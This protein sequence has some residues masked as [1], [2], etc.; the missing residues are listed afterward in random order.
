M[1]A[2]EDGNGRGAGRAGRSR[3]VGCRWIV[4]S[5]AGVLCL[6][7]GPSAGAATATSTT[8]VVCAP[9]PVRPGA[10]TTCAATVTGPVHPTGT[11]SFA[12]NSSGTF[13]PVTC[14]LSQLGGNQARCTVAY[15]PAAATGPQRIYAN[16]SGDTGI[17]PSHGSSTVDVELGSTPAPG[18]V[19]ACS[20]A[21]IGVSETTVCT[22]TVTGGTP[23]PTGTVSFESGDP[24]D[25][26][27][28][29]VC[30]LMQS[31]G[32]QARCSVTYGSVPFE[33][34]TRKIIGS[35]SG[36][37][38]NAPARGSTV[39]EHNVTSAA[40]VACAPTSVAVGSP[41][42]CTAT[43]AGV[44]GSG[45]PTGQV[46]FGQNSSGSLSAAGCTLVAGPGATASCSVTYTPGAVGTGSHVIY[47]NYLGDVQHLPDYG[48]TGIAV[49][50]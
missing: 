33:S 50:P 16:F 22:A 21:S 32:T 34:G 13:T 4:A 8:T 45:T 14:T 27:S 40:S 3:A 15:V 10:P 23:H 26:F 39:V 29:M 41:T 48:S 9:S 18:I 1:R 6:V 11:V 25:T 42:T 28:P 31:G 35:Y 43:V 19:V 38:T 37:A 44:D 30:T 46:A 12:G 49:T 47:V 5:L 20:P 2:L 7:A 24:R 36:D 17:A